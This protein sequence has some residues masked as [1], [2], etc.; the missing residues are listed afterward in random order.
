MNKTIRAYSILIFLATAAT[1]CAPAAIPTPATQTS[2]PRP[3]TAVATPA[4][5]IAPAP[6][7]GVFVPPS[8]CALNDFDSQCAYAQNQ[9][10]AVTI[11]TR[12]AGSPNGTRA[13][14]YIADQFKS[15]GYVVDKQEF[16]FEPWEDLGTKVL[17]TAADSREL[18]VI[19]IQFS[20]AGH[21]EAEVVA[22]GGVG[23]PSDYAKV[24]VKGK[25][26]FVQR[27]T[28]QF[29][30]KSKNAADAGAIAVIVYNNAPQLFGGTM[31]ERS[32]IPTLAMSG[33]ESDK[34][35]TAL[36][37]GTV[38][39]KIDSDTQV[40]K[41]IA[42]NII[43][44]KPGTNGKTLVLGGHYDTVATA[45]GANDNGSGTAVL[46][47][48]ARVLGK[49]DL[50]YTLVFIAFDAEE[51]GLIGSRYYAD[52]LSESE[53]GKI[54]AMLNFDMLA[55]GK[56]A[57]GLGGDGAIAQAARQ[58]AS[59]LGIDARNFQLGNNA[60]SDHQSFTRLGIDS[61]FFSR[62]YD[63]LH[64]PQDSLDQIHA[65]WLGE[66]GK[67]ALQALMDLNSK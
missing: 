18:E 22:V 45:P 25:I 4:P 40:T 38:K 19:P 50:K 32:I 63:L 44:T 2:A 66:A 27:G 20:S 67:V 30:D 51:F 7:Q 55:G 33:R 60:G 65:D 31:R 3:P 39:V 37:A 13:G 26:A 11:G 17:L 56:G 8:S 41:K 59:A 53:R 35:L 48:L 36:N 28:L 21:L 62:D 16:T 12:V 64:T 58:A 47:E 34:I 29:Y 42:H 23:E 57:L 52:H 10:L 46:I 6:T 5:I 15:F 24:N 9:M 54:A 49:R 43:A 1:A 61:V 14:D